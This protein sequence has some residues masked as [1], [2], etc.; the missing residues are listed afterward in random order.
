MF[1]CKKILLIAPSNYNY[2]QSIKSEIE[3]MGGI[4]HFYDERNNPNSFQKFIFRKAPVILKRRIVKYF[5]GIAK[6]E[7]AFS[8]DYVLFISP[9]TV[10]ESAI[11]VLRNSLSKAKFILYMWDSIENKNAKKIYS[12]FDKCLSFDSNDCKKYGFIFRPLFFPSHFTNEDDGKEEYFYDFGFIGVMHSDRAKIIYQIMNY[13]RENN[14]KY[15]F[16]LY[17][18]GKL[19]FIYRYITNKYIRALFALGMVHTRVLDRKQVETI[20]T[21]TRCIIDVNHPNQTGLTM[22]TIEIL[23]LKR[24]LLTTNTNIKDYDF[25]LPA[26]QIVID[27]NKITLDIDLIAKPYESIPDEIFYK[28]RIDY[29]IKEVFA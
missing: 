1:H 8:P 3:K 14:L 17:V 26:N 6:A 16:Y 23:G 19:M 2:P 24:K 29:W 5:S 18:Q 15:Y 13:C 12:L 7:E 9:E 10:T 28:Y 20:M 4:V 21:K 11:K 22:R 25:Y 27:R